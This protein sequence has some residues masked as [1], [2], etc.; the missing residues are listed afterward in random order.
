MSGLCI[1]M[2]TVLMTCFGSGRF[3]L[4]AE[5]ALSNLLRIKSTATSDGEVHRIGR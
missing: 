5:K 3:F 1:I 2:D 4:S